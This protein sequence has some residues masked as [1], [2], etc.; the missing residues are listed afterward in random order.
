MFVVILALV[1]LLATSAFQQARRYAFCLPWP[2]CG[3]WETGR[4]LLEPSGAQ[5]VPV[6]TTRY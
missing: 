4:V 5:L 2:L 1:I 3:A 6:G